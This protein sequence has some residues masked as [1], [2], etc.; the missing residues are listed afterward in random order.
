MHLHGWL[1]HSGNKQVI[2]KKGQPFL[3]F[4]NENGTAARVDHDGVATW[5]NGHRIRITKWEFDTIQERTSRG[6]V[7]VRVFRFAWKSC[8]PLKGNVG[9]ETTQ[10]PAAVIDNPL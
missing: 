4:R 6:I 3:W 7:P 1:R 2:A 8:V 9:W 5:F 10:T